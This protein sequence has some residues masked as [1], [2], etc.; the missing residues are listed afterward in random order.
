MP[1]ALL[2]C[3]DAEYRWL[4]P[5]ERV[6]LPFSRDRA[7]LLLLASRYDICLNGD[8]LTHIESIGLAPL[9]IPLAQVFARVSPDQKEL[10]LVTLR[11]AGRWG[12][13]ITKFSL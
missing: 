9:L 3:A 12:P 13:D 10:V 8:S 4:S 7:D 5:D 6:Q 11:A 2:R 1:S